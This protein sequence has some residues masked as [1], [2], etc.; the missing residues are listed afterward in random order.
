MAMWPWRNRGDRDAEALASLVASARR[1]DYG[2]AYARELTGRT[3]AGATAPGPP[4]PE[5]PEVR[6]WTEHG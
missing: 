3:G 4:L 1:L 2:G 5:V 6:W